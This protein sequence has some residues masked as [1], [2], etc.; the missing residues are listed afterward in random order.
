MEV[1]KLRR[2]KKKKKNMSKTESGSIS[3]AKGWQAEKVG[4]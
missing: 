2:K 1:T 4:S 3:T